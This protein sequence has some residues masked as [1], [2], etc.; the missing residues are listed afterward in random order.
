MISRLKTVI[1]IAVVQICAVH[2][3]SL[4]TVITDDAA[5]IPLFGQDQVLTLTKSVGPGEGLFAISITDPSSGGS[6]YTFDY[7]GIAEEYALFA[8]DFGTV[9]DPNFAASTTPLVSNNGVDPGSSLQTF[10][11]GESRYFGY[12]DERTLNDSATPNKFDNYGW[13][14]IERTNSG[15]EVSS[16]ATAIGGGIIA[17]TLISVPEPPAMMLLLLGIGLCSRMRRLAA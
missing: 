5:I 8:V 7:F 14:L 13:V 12:W 6:G 4:A 16:S 17:G 2:A 15:L 1:A 11:I 10:L 3:Q 9:I